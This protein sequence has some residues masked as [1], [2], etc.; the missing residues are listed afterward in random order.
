MAD[1]RGGHAEGA[2]WAGVD[3]GLLPL[4]AVGANTV[5]RYHCGLP[6][7]ASQ[8]DCQRALQRLEVIPMALIQTRQIGTSEKAVPCRCTKSCFSIKHC[9]AP[10]GGMHL[11]KAVEQWLGVTPESPADVWG[12]SEP[13]QPKDLAVAQMPPWFIVVTSSHSNSN[14]VGQSVLRSCAV[15]L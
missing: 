6:S 13:T 15:T 2:T 4:W 8:W 14:C 7:R 5:M 1:R 3:D 11:V 12:L 9:P 10:A